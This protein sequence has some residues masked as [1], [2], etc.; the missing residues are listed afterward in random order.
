MILRGDAATG[1]HVAISLAAMIRIQPISNARPVMRRQSR[2]AG[3][4]RQSGDDEFEMRAAL[5]T[6]T[7][8]LTLH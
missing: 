5:Q 4:D 3:Q 2:A 1:L 7:S 6:Q 8:F